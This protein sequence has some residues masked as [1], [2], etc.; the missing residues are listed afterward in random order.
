[1]QDIAQNSF[2]SDEIDFEA[3]KVQADAHLQKSLP[4]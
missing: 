4:D 1:M 2:C 3:M